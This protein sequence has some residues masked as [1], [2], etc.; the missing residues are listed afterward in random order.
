[1]CH[2]CWSFGGREA[3]EGRQEAR[4]VAETCRARY[5]LPATRPLFFGPSPP[6]RCPTGGLTADPPRIT[7]HRP[8]R[9]P[10]GPRQ[11]PCTPTDACHLPALRPVSRP[12]PMPPASRPTSAAPPRLGR[13]H[14][15]LVV[16][17]YVLCDPLLSFG[18]SPFPH[19][20]FTRS[21]QLGRAPAQPGVIPFHFPLTTITPGST[22]AAPA[23]RI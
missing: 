16:R 8:L 9:F 15:S 10:L 14:F 7:R 1:M 23:L 18:P 20:V 17:P 19:P 3:R 4:A 2:E 6:C 5:A 11:P 21:G 22:P 12:F 13:L